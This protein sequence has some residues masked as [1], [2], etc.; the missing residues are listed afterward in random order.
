MTRTFSLASSAIALMTFVG[1]AQAHQIWIEQQAG[2]KTAIVRFGEFG[3]NLRETS[4]GLLDKFGKPTATLVS[5]KGDRKVDAEKTATGFA[6]PFG[7]G[8]ND[9]IVAEDAGYPLYTWKQGDKETLNRYYPAARLVTGFAAV[10]PKLVLDLVP[11]GTE[12]EFKLVFKDQP[13]PKTKVTLVTQSGWV[14]E[15]HT[16]DQGRVKFD[17]PWKGTY[18]AEASLT[19]ATAGERQGATGTEKFEGVSYVTT[20]TYVKP[21]GV[22]PIAAGP[23]AKPHK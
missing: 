8:R 20:L 21:S 14:K 16:D 11:T 10:A 9:T 23:A 1:A 7:A 6:L 17:M 2:Q 3:E 18:V 12:G 22:A 13:K 4:P 19:D 15:G 5:A